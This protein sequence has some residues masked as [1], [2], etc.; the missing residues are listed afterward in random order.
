MATQHKTLVISDL[1]GGR[2]GVD[3]PLSLPDTQCVEALNIDL[4][5]TLLGKKRAG[6]TALTITWDTDHVL[7]N[8]ATSPWTSTIRALLNQAYSNITIGVDGNTTPRWAM[9]T[10]AALAEWS[11]ISMTDA[12]T[13]A[14]NIRGAN[15]GSK[16]FICYD[17]AV[18]RLHVLDPTSL[19]IRRVGLSTP[20][21]APTAAD[22][23]SGTYPATARYYKVAWTTQVTGVTTLRSELSAVKTFTASGSGASVRVTQPTPPAEGETHWELYASANG[24]LYW[25]IATTAI[26]TTYHDDTVE[27]AYYS[28]ITGTA[29]PVVGEN[30]VPVDWNVIGANGTRLFGAGTYGTNSTPY[31]LWYTPVRGASDVGDD[32]RVPTNNYIDITSND[33]TAPITGIV[34]DFYGNALVFK[35]QSLYRLVPTGDDDA[36][37]RVVCLSRTVGATRQE[38]IVEAEDEHGAPA[39]YFWGD[40]GPYRMSSVGIEYCGA[41]IEDYSRPAVGTYNVS[42]AGHGVY[43]RSRHQVWFWIGTTAA[44]KPTH[45]F[46]FDTRHGRSGVNGVRGGWVR[47]SGKSCQAYCSVIQNGTPLVGHTEVAAIILRGDTGTQDYAANYQAYIKT[48]PYALAGL[49][50]NFSLGQSHLTAKAGDGVTI[51]QTLDRDYG[52]ETRTS[53]CLLTATAAA[54]TRVQRQFEGSDL[55]EAGVVQFQIG[56]AAAANVTWT[57]DALAVPYSTHEER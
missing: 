49:G 17:S 34:G 28:T 57:L 13:A 6:S 47:H 29:P 22:Q 16:L 8:P 48:K 44:T 38:L 41:D 25:L 23:G 18:A 26:A 46:V 39:V 55:N 32:E 4:Y 9:S 30:T 20:P 2:N 54:E 56:D 1:R 21:A 43:Y 31:R 5:G 53:T 42:E 27:V 3:A 19:V 12:A 50:H 7:Y 45:R 33:D 51:T 36:P 40:R 24:T 35:A 37:Y 14:T 52:L 11:P 10:T 15:L